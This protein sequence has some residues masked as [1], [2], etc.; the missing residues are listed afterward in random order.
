MRAYEADVY[1][2]QRALRA[3]MEDGSPPFELEARFSAV[4]ASF[5]EWLERR[6]S[7]SSKWETDTTFYIHDMFVVHPTH[8]QIRC[9]RTL[10]DGNPMQVETVT[11]KRL[12]CADLALPQMMDKDHPRHMRLTL[13]SEAPVELDPSCL[14]VVKARIGRR[15]RFVIGRFAYDL[16]KTWMAEDISRARHMHDTE[17]PTEWNVEIEFLPD[18]PVSDVKRTCPRYIVTSLLLKMLNCLQSV[19]NR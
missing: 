17:P 16:T 7:I 9:R 3:A 14:E 8:G 2:A 19:S 11:K 6:M 18:T 5:Y 10:C 1:A 12:F 13:A 15:R 4:D